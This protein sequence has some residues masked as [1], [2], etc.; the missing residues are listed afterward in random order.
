MRAQ[1]LSLSKGGGPHSVLIIAGPTASG[2]SALAMDVAERFTG[3]VINADSQQVYSELRLL[4]ARPSGP[5]E[6][7]VPHRLFGIVRG[8]AGCSAGRWVDLA[9]VEIKA[10]Q[11]ENRLPILVGGTGMY[12]QSLTQGLSPIPNIPP[13]VRGEAMAR[14]AELGA[15]AFHAEVVKL[16]PVAGQ[17]LPVGDTQR[18][19]RAWEVTTYTGQA[20]SVWR[21]APRIK[22][23]ADMHF[24]TIVLAPPRDRL[25]A[26]INARFSRMVEAGAVDEVRALAA[27]DLDPDL[28]LM[29]A[30][31][32][33]ELLAFIHGKCTLEQA[34]KRAQQLSRNYAKRQL[35]WARHQIEGAYI[36]DTQYSQS[37][38]DEIFAFVQQFLLTRG[39]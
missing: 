34:V 22:P 16:D 8:G 3:T 33:P 11:A 21:D 7:R 1:D 9:C 39:A 25:Y 13:S 26:A 18:L 23:L 24:S 32:V 29:K 30:L 17:R 35:T 28:P 19:L 31:G 12:L 2:K 15:E 37:F 5:D 38:Q 14:H 36:L 4:T 27:L 6:K 20:F 10:A